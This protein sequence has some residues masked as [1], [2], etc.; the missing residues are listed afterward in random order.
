M[1][2]EKRQLLMSK[3]GLASE[4]ELMNLSLTLLKW[5]VGEIEQGN[6]P[7]SYDPIEDAVEK[8]NVEAFKNIPKKGTGV[9]LRI[10]R[11]PE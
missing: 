2:S 11:D 3:L 10:V 5:A 9:R 7:A 8:L 4:V 1:S 6:F